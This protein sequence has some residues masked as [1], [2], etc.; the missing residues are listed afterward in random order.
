M[1]QLK[2]VQFSVWNNKMSDLFY[3]YH[4]RQRSFQA[5]ASTQRVM[6]NTCFGSSIGARKSFCELSTFAAIEPSETVTVQVSETKTIEKRIYAD[7][8][9]LDRIAQVVA[10]EPYHHSLIASMNVESSDEVF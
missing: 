5:L 3:W 6:E 8:N 2:M 10:Q 4:F 1:E 7:L 9:E